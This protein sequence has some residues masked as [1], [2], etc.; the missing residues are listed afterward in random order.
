MAGTFF[1]ML[2]SVQ[3]MME[4]PDDYGLAKKTC[5]LSGSILSFIKNGSY[6]KSD[7]EKFI[8]SHFDLGAKKMT[9]LWNSIHPSSMKSVNTFRG[10]ISILS[11]YVAS[12]YSFMDEDLYSYTIKNDV[13]SLEVMNF[14]SIAFP[15]S[16]V[17]ISER[18]AIIDY[19]LPKDVQLKHF[20]LEECSYELSLLKTFDSQ[21]LS[22]LF[23]KADKEKLAFLLS[24]MKKPLISSEYRELVDKVKPV[25]VAVLDEI[26]LTFCHYFE[27]AGL[28][29]L[30]EG[31]LQVEKQNLGVVQAGLYPTL[32][33][34]DEMKEI[35][36]QVSSRY[37]DYALSRDKAGK[38]NKFI[39]DD[40]TQDDAEIYAFLN[41]LT[42]DG[43]KSKLS[44][45]N[46]YRLTVILNSLKEG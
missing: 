34:S 11:N 26:K 38:P 23:N 5:L 28:M 29:T 21:N 22:S 14:I 41:T 42:L 33:V 31:K 3:S 40:Y 12:I 6:L 8:V 15:L 18:F 19:F 35:L 16:L 1:N 9:E 7:V 39:K 32:M 46:T 20:E 25:K 2:S 45:F 27:D 4:N 24:V 44:S 17:D 10:Q 43:F 13:A 37:E 36:S 30:E